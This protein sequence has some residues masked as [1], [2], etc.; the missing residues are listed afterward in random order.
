[1]AACYEDDMPVKPETVDRYLEVGCEL[2]GTPNCKVRAWEAELV[3]V[4]FFRGAE[5][6]DPNGLLEKPGENSRFARYLR[7]TDVDSI[8]ELRKT[9]LSYIEEAVELEKS[10]KP[11]VA[12]DDGSMEYP[13]ELKDAFAGDPE[14]AKAFSD[15]TPGRQRGYLIHFSSA[16]QSKT[17]ATRIEKAKEK[18]YAGKGWNER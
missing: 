10:G 15:L 2:G 18:I 5:L 13:E 8:P 3:V 16:K 11:A 1:M 4:S 12:S 14:F 7:V 6:K 9:I 17:R